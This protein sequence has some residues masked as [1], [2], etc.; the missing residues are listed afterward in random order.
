MNVLRGEGD[1][2]IK[3]AEAIKNEVLQNCLDYENKIKEYK[4]ILLNNLQARGT[5][6]SKIYK[7]LEDF[8][9]AYKID[10]KTVSLVHTILGN[11]LSRQG[12]AMEAVN[13]FKKAISINNKNPS[14][15]TSLGLILYK[16]EKFKDAIKSLSIA[17]DLFKEQE[18][19]EEFDQI[20]QIIFKT[21]QNSNLLARFVKWL[22]Y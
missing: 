17:R 14:A 11:E 9:K 13:L 16:Q 21:K 10:N 12:K 20:E 8:Q 18:M 4:Q 2:S 22:L 3:E 1:I 5:L 6:D 19:T 15:H 7:Q